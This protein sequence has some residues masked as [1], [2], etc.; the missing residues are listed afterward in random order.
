MPLKCLKGS[1]EVELLLGNRFF[2]RAKIR[3]GGGILFQNLHFR[4]WEISPMAFLIPR[5]PYLII[6]S[7]DSVK[8]YPKDIDY[9]GINIP[10][11]NVEYKMKNYQLKCAL[12]IVTSGDSSAN[13]D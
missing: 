6:P 2:P 4:G 12:A 13:P 11:H 7:P 5:T 1:V 8:I 10:C 9:V 3:A